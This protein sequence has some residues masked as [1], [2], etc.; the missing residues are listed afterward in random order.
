MEKKKLSEMEYL[1]MQYIWQHPDGVSSGNIYNEFPQAL[2]TKSVILH[3]IKEKG[4]VRAERNGR[5]VIY[6][7]TTTMS[8]YERMLMEDKIQRTMGVSSLGELIASLC[9]KRGLTKE[10][11][12]ELYDLIDRIKD[13]ENE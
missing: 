4:Y 9:G 8:E 2:G 5:K 6:K 7:A 13:D 10:Q 3:N 11:A 1:F 12:N